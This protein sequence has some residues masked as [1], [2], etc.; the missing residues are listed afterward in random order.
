M[1]SGKQTVVERKMIRDWPETELKG[2]KGGGDS[3][4]KDR[5]ATSQDDLHRRLVLQQISFDDD[6]F[7]LAQHYLDKFLPDT[8]WQRRWNAWSSSLRLSFAEVSTKRSSDLYDIKQ[9]AYAAFTKVLIETQLKKSEQ[10]HLCK[11]E[12]RIC[13]AFTYAGSRSQSSVPLW[14]FCT[15]TS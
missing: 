2:G 13:S 15:S 11:K 12:N 10:N 9:A 7:T 6:L 1:D 8:D 14:H 3:N 5:G 4:G